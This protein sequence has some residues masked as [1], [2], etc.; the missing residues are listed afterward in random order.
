MSSERAVPSA[1]STHPLKRSAWAV[2]VIAALSAIGLL[3]SGQRSEHDWEVLAARAPGGARVALVRGRSC[4][5]GPCQT[6]WV[7]P[8]R[9]S[10]VQ[11]GTLA[12]G[13]EQCDEISW[14]PDG[15]RVGFLVN[16]YQLRIYDAATL[17][18]AGQFSLIEPDGNP[19]TRI[20]RGVTF[21]EN[22]RAVTF[23]DCPR[24][25]SGCRAG[26]VAVPQ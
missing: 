4:E 18:P 11:V 2:L 21:S 26:L 24:A 19:T 14:T 1:R 8:T 7:G 3:L 10:A 13:R 22:G 6:L 5:A 17:A 20:A 12:P 9:E 23:D 16:G 15:T 25:R